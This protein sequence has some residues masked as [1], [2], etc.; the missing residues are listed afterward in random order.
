M[1]EKQCL[2]LI[3]GTKRIIASIK[4]LLITLLN[5]I[6]NLI[7]MYMISKAELLSHQLKI[8]N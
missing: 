5:G 3:I 4:Y 7:H 8:S 6:L 1:I 2:R